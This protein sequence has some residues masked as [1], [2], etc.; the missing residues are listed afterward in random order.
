M[1]LLPQTL[2]PAE[3]IDVALSA[4]NATARVKAKEL[5]DGVMA[6]RL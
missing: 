2:E 3:H 1:T 4:R 6:K 5:G